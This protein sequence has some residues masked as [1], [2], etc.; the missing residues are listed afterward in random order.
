MRSVCNFEL[1]LTVLLTAGNFFNIKIL[2][3]KIMNIVRNVW[4]VWILCLM[5]ANLY[6]ATCQFLLI[7]MW[8][9]RLFI[10]NSA[11]IIYPHC[12][13]ICYFF[14]WSYFITMSKVRVGTEFHPPCPQNCNWTNEASAQ[15]SNDQELVQH[16]S[17]RV[18][19]QHSAVNI[20]HS[21]GYK[22]WQFMG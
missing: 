22:F 8:K 16:T 19:A 14:K 2:N 5:S 18:T 7:K 20:Q 13:F 17:E 11:I 10:M 9:W 15:P 6:V 3:K 1:F 12:S 21:V 4:N